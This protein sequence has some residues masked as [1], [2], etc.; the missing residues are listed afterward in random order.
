MSG[1]YRWS[2][3]LIDVLLLF[4]NAIPIVMFLYYVSV[5]SDDTINSYMAMLMLVL[6][7]LCDA[8]ELI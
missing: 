7:D 1:A 2:S 4:I 8:F 6:M 3:T 5:M